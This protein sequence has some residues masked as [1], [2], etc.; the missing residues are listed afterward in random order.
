MT[1]RLSNHI[2]NNGERGFKRQMKEVFAFLVNP[3]NGFN[4]ILD[5]RWGR[6][7][8]N[9][10]DDTARIS[11]N[12]I[13]DVGARRFSTKINGI[14]DQGDNEFYIR[15]RLQYGPVFEPLKIP[16]SSFNLLVEAGA[17]DSAHLNQIYVNGILKQW[18]MN[19]TVKHR[20]LG[21]FTMNYDY[22]LNN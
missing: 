16:F 11:I 19:E 13:L 1:Y 6:V 20:H 21:S 10:R 4:R 2:V 3:M 15:L 17:A 22:F 7:H 12:A 14:L 8:Y 9:T 18:I 5:G